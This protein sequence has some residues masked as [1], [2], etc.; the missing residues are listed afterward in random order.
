M[1]RGK[2]RKA[3]AVFLVALVIRGALFAHV[4]NQ[5][6]TMLQPDSSIYISLAKG[7]IENGSFSNQAISDRPSADRTPGYPFFLAAILWAFRESL[8]AAVAIQILLDSVSCVMVCKL[9]EELWEGNGYLSGILASINI[10]MITY[11]NFILTDSL[12]VFCFL[13]T[14]VVF[15]GFLRQP[16]WRLSV[17]LGLTLGIATMVRPVIALLPL[18]LIP[19][20]AFALVIKHR[21][22]FLPAAGR[23]L[24]IGIL[25]VICLS[26]W[27]M[28]NYLYCG[29]WSLTAQSG[30]H[31]LQY[32]VPFTW[33]YSRGVPFIEGMKKT[34][35]AFKEKA[36][37]EKLNLGKASPFELSDLKVRMAVDYLR[38]EPKTAIAK[39]WFFGMVK[40]LFAPAIIDFSYLLNIERPHFFYT[41]GK[42][43]LERAWNFV[44][45]MRGWFGWAVIGSM[46]LL[47]VSRIL[48]LW[49]LV[50]VSRRKPWEGFLLFL[51][52]VYF[53]IVS[54]PVGYAKYRLPLE[55]ILIVLLSVG[56]R[57]IYGRWIKRFGGRKGWRNEPR[58]ES[59]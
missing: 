55:P 18:V 56:L 10:G 22:N 2:W 4:L 13:L 43:T 38:K 16:S 34:D 42:T 11:A 29:R 20:L 9:G 41:E 50:Q 17:I 53:L 40:N 36:S 21:E 32:I 47:V 58:I 37:K 33:Q 49:G 48:Q 52:I 57:D 6:G 25:F 45:G 19:L 1:S 8:V 46:M 3:F 5:P 14:L 23:A 24:M 31:L 27:M 15:L 28:R 54:G 7:L 30:D 35:A 59:P 12:F 51:F 39:A 26:P 44:K